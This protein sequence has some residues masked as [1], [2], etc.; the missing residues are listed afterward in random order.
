MS[1][2]SKY[3]RGTRLITPCGGKS[4]TKQSFSDECNIN[5]IISRYQISGTVSHL[6]KHEANYGFATS[7][8]LHEAMNI[9]S[10][11]ESMFAELPS[12]VRREFG[13]SPMRF[14]DFVQDEENVGKLGDLLPAL[15]APG[16]QLP[17]VDRGV[18]PPVL[19]D[20]VE[21]EGSEPAEPA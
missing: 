6:A 10:T 3:K 2:K 13:N 18:L 7:A 17:Q 21:L 4:R 15:A 8:D 9:V 20:P 11:A 5:N 14:L 1:M 16:D 12:E 19:V